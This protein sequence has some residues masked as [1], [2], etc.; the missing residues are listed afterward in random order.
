MDM[1][2]GI[3]MQG[4]KTQFEKKAYLGIKFIPY[5]LDRLAVHIE[6]VF[7]VMI[8]GR[9]KTTVSCAD[10]GIVAYPFG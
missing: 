9:I 10:K 7:G 3:N 5:L 4:L 2:M 6:P 8:E 1:V